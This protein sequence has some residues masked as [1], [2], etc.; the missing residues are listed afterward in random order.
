MNIVYTGKNDP[1][2]FKEVASETIARLVEKDPDVI[3]LDADVMSCIGT[4]GW[5]KTHTDRAINCGIAES[6]MVGIAC[7]LSA[8]G[9]KPIVHSFGPFVSRRVFDQVFLSG[10]YAKNDITI[11]GSD[12]GVVAAFNGGTHMPFEDLAMYRAIPG[13]TVFDIADPNMLE[14]VLE[15]AVN[16]PGVKYIRTP[17]KLAATIYEKGETLPVGKAIPLREGTDAVI[18]A[19]GIMVHE[20]MQAAAQLEAEGVSVSVV[21]VFTIKPIDAET[22]LKSCEGKKAVLV[23]E[24]HN[25]FGGLYSAVCEVIAGKVSANVGCVAVND[26]FGEVGSVGYL[27]ERFGL[28]AASIVK[29]LKELL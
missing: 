29:T 19:S 18:F 17:R 4:L 7:G 5:A 6:N 14:S 24:N 15:Q 1:R 21:N 2:T 28:T 25:K 11:I 13:A 16:L 12:P 3:Y 10:G 23:T 8:A 27:Q 22:I 26:S 20:A 9:F